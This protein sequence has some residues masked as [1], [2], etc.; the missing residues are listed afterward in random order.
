MRVSPLLYSGGA[1][2][3]PCPSVPEHR[4]DR[5]GQESQSPEFC[6]VRI[7]WQQLSSSQNLGSSLSGASNCLIFAR[8]TRFKFARATRPAILKYARWVLENN[9]PASQLRREV[10]RGVQIFFE[11]NQGVALARRAKR[12]RKAKG[13]TLSEVE[14]KS[15]IG[16]IT[17]HTQYYAPLR[18]CA[19]DCAYIGSTMGHICL[20]GSDEDADVFWVCSNG[21]DIPWE[22]RAVEIT[23]SSEQISLRPQRLLCLL[24]EKTGDGRGE[25]GL[26][27]PVHC[28]PFGCVLG[29]CLHRRCRAGQESVRV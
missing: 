16:E 19:G 8:A 20:C 13:M 2:Y 25:F 5:R 6:Y 28:V 4:P 9:F 7:A 26:F 21:K 10:N 11:D 18:P 22:R 29:A 14:A 23:G 27:D 17:L 24:P 15:G 1:G 3:S 12:I